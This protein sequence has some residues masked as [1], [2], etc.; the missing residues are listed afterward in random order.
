MKRCLIFISALVLGLLLMSCSPRLI[1]N[2]PPD[3]ETLILEDTPLGSP[4]ALVL[5]YA[6]TKKWPIT[7]YGT[8]NVHRF[9]AMGI[10]GKQVIQAF[11][12]AY[13]GFA[14]KEKVNFYWAFQDG[15]LFKVYADKE[16][17]T[18]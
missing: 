10:D 5:N 11:M 14:W 3:M 12:G 13:Q 7:E 8:N 17:Y 15:K 2:T 1:R 4:Y 18:N 6:K 9:P 16:E